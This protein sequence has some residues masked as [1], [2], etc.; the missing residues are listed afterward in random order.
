[1]DTRVGPIDTPF[2]VTYVY[3]IGDQL[4]EAAYANAASAWHDARRPQY[5]NGDGR[6]E[7]EPDLNWLRKVL[8]ELARTIIVAHPDD[9]SIDAE[10]TAEVRARER[11]LASL[12]DTGLRKWLAA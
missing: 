4:S 7:P 8:A 6:L 12:G 3:R 1:M 2:G 5:V 9:Y 10:K 11:H